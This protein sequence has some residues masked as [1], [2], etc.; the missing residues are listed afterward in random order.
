MSAKEMM[1]EALEK[2]LA[3]VRF[4]DE[5]S[6][7]YMATYF[8]DS[9]FVDDEYTDSDEREVARKYQPQLMKLKD[10][11]NELE[12]LETGSVIRFVKAIDEI[13]EEVKAA[14]V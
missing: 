3:E 8:T 13:M 9:V 10:A 5:F 7:I 11:V 1:I 12:D 14:A 4:D 2:I 6:A